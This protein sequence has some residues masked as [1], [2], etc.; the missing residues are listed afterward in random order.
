[1]AACIRAKV[2]ATVLGM[3]FCA[4][5]PEKYHCGLLT[6][7][8]VAAGRAIILPANINHLN[9]EPMIIGRPSGKVNAGTIVLAVTHRRRSGKL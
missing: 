6:R 7:D 5:L 4:R 9:R 2:Y 3:S 1:M 8:E